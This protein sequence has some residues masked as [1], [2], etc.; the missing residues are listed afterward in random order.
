MNFG[1][2]LFNPPLMALPPHLSVAGTSAILD[3]DIHEYPR[4]RI[5]PTCC[6]FWGCGC[7][8]NGAVPPSFDQSNKEVVP[9]KCYRMLGT[10]QPRMTQLA[11]L[12]L[13][14]KLWEG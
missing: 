12:G 1:G 3:E 14:Q 5:V 8:H 11:K 13:L 7:H 9:Q 2:T 4:L 6:I 10:L